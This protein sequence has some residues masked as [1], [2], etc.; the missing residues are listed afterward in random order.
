MS[1]ESSRR[2]MLRAV[3]GATSVGLVGAMPT[4]LM[5]GHGDQPVNKL[6]ALDAQ[7]KG[8]HTHRSPEPVNYAP[9]LDGR[10]VEIDELVRYYHCLD[11]NWREKQPISEMFASPLGGMGLV[12]GTITP[13]NAAA[14]P[15]AAY[16]LQM[17]LRLTKAHMAVPEPQIPLHHNLFTHMVPIYAETPLAN[18][19]SV[20]GSRLGLIPPYVDVVDPLDLKDPNGNPIPVQRLLSYRYVTD[21]EEPT[22]GY[23]S[24]ANMLLDATISV[25]RALHKLI[26]SARA[27]LH[28]FKQNRPEEVRIQVT[29]FRTGVYREGFMLSFMAWIMG[30]G[31]MRYQPETG[32]QMINEP[33]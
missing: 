6:E 18:C 1:M 8:E 7:G 5:A 27:S 32:L 15:F 11:H 14:Q 12:D 31:W 16:P 22:F 13:T 28:E 9:L 17:Y 26:E 19:C 3:L 4:K 33:C 23:R 21:I 10:D 20:L 24:T 25:W 29:P 2:G 30:A